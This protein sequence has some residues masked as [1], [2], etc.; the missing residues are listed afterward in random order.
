MRKIYKYPIYCDAVDKGQV[1]VRVD[2][3]VGAKPIS[4]QCQDG[5][6]CV[7]AEVDP[8]IRSVSTHRFYCVGTGYGDVPEDKTFLGTVQQGAFVWHIYH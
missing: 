5:T 2:M 6:V 3:P 8:K 7:W 1:I 4:V